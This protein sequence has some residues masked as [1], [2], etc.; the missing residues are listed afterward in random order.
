LRQ[1]S[2]LRS[3]EEPRDGWGEFDGVGDDGCGWERVEEDEQG[4]GIWMAGLA[5][6]DGIVAAGSP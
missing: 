1:I 5:A 6:E 2:A 4:S 3:F